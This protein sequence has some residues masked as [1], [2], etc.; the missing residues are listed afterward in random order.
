MKRGDRDT[1]GLQNWKCD[2]GAGLASAV[3]ADQSIG[4]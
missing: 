4:P 3:G 1:I 2:C